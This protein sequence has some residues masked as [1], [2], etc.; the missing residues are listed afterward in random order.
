MV[1]RRRRYRFNWT[2]P[3]AVDKFDHN[4]V[5]VGSQYVHMTS[6]A[7]Q[8]WKTFSSDLTRNDKSHQQSS[9]G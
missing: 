1:A 9:G 8:S 4:R 5:Y 6:D 2:F 3:I 7:G